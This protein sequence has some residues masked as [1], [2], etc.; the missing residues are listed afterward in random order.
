MPCAR[1]I[2][3]GWSMMRTKLPCSAALQLSASRARAAQKPWPS[4]PRTF[5]LAGSPRA[6]L[7]RTASPNRFPLRRR[8]PSRNRLSLCPALARAVSG[9]TSGFLLMRI[10]L[11]RLRPTLR[12][13]RCP[14]QES[15]LGTTPSLQCV[16]DAHPR[17]WIFEMTEEMK[18]VDGILGNFKRRRQIEKDVA[19]SKS[20]GR[21]RP[22]V[23]ET[24]P[25]SVLW[26]EI[27]S[28]E[29]LVDEKG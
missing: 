26:N 7:I 15:R 16:P 13:Q 23:R 2:R 20:V 10:G 9:R 6:R 1:C 21:T 18:N 4:A 27:H 11:V 5:P 22:R 12:S 19:E 17:R 28:E 24:M 8:P 14:P 3:A 25:G 29:R